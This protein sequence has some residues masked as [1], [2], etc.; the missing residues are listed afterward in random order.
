[1]PDREPA[2]RQHLVER[3][4]GGRV[5]FLSVDNAAKLNVLDAA[6]SR[7]LGDKV[8]ALAGDDE[9]RALVL[10][11]VGERAFIGGADIG[12]MAA[13]EPHSA[14]AFI[15][16]LHEACLALRALPVPVIAR[17]QGYC[18]GGGLE[19]AVA[20][21]LRLAAESARFGMP[22]VRLGIPSVIEAALLPTLVG[23]GKA[24]E[25]VLTGEMIGAEEALACGL[26]ERVVPDHDLDAAL[27]RWLAAVC[28]GAPE[29]VRAQ[30]ALI[31]RWEALPLD[32]GI[33][34]GVEAFV[35]AYRTGEPNRLMRR[36]LEGKR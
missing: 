5:A 32:E 29:A 19:V 35:T 13:L 8:G 3:D 14:R 12:E 22:E 36:F 16:A 25:L 11:G 1:M 26:V 31:R 28:A 18:L 4:E 24:R 2:I 7:E 21:D 15:T 20:C 6:L 9:L 33:E 17:I 34:A 10:T 23:W 30:K 27:E